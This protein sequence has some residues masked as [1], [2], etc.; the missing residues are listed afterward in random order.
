MVF[1]TEVEMYVPVP[2]YQRIELVRLSVTPAGTLSARITSDWY[3]NAGRIGNMS[4]VRAT[5]LLVAEPVA[6]KAN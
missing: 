6:V 5:L 2:S 1:V 4:V 3:A